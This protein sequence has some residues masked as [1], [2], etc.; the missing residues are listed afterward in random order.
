MYTAY[1]TK[2]HIFPVHGR[3]VFAGTGF[4]LR[5]AAELPCHAQRASGQ[6]KNLRRDV[7]EGP[8]FEI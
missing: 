3:T 1:F 2:A 6:N 5:I 8:L 7:R 4:Q